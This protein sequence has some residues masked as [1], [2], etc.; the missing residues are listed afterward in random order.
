M[1][2]TL[3]QDNKENSFIVQNNL[4]LET[5]RLFLSK[6]KDLDSITLRGSSL[7][8]QENLLLEHISRYEVIQNNDLYMIDIC[9]HKESICQTWKIR[10]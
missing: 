8:F 7:Y 3:V 9:I 1:I 2:F 4:I 6:Q 5:T 10:L